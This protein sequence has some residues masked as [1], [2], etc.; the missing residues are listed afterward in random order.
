MDALGLG[1]ESPPCPE[2]QEEEIAESLVNI[3]KMQKTQMKC[4]QVRRRRAGLGGGDAGQRLG[5]W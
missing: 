1:S 3:Q 2:A 5:V 4:R